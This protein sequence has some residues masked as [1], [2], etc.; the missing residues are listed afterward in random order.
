MK[1]ETIKAI[2]KALKVKGGK[3]FVIDG[4]TVTIQS[5]SRAQAIERRDKVKDT[6]KD[7]T[8]LQGIIEYDPETGL[9]QKLQIL[10]K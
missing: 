3:C 7:F 4:D 9:Y 10:K 5:E 8:V 2:E 6:L 1:K